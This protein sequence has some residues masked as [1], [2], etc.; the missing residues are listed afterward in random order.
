MPAPAPAAPP[1]AAPPAPPSAVKIVDTGPPKPPPAPTTVIR[2][3]ELPPPVEPLKPPAKGSA[4]ADMLKNLRSRAK[5]ESG[6]TAPAETPPAE[7]QTPPET[8]PVETPAGEKPTETP[9]ATEVKPGEKEKANPWKLVDQYKKRTAELEKEIAAVKTSTLPEQERATYTEKIT[10]LEASVKQYE[11][12]L[13]FMDYSQ[14]Q[15]FK[16]KYAD[17]FQNAWNVAMGELKEISITDPGTGQ[18]RPMGV[19]DMMQI[20]NLPLGQARDV[21]N[22]IAGDFADDIMAHRKEIRKL[23][24][25]QNQA[26]EK[27]KKDG[28]ER[29]KKEG[30]ATQK[31][32]AEITKTLA[33]TWQEE[34]TA[35]LN[36]EKYGK[37]LKPVEGD[38]EWNT[39]LKRGF[40]RADQTFADKSPK[41]PTLT[42]DERA[43]IVKRHV[44]MRNRSAAFGALRYR[45]E[46]QQAR[47]AELEAKL[48]EYDETVPPTAGG[49]HAE[50]GAPGA[51][52][53]AKQAVYGALRGLAK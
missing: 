11:D 41:D 15:E 9:P 22:K 14:S 40:E 19:D 52:T 35:L 3:S 28:A 32:T 18:Q 29:V 7:K 33:T 37:Y 10:K 47:I 30:E 2:A 51:P 31:Q 26:L 1:P 4:R 12:K 13:A 8:K 34:N 44:A 53:T 21:A 6:E 49:G 20:V 5:N 27:A 36:H 38:E 50:P 42:P 43:E 16:E 25:A 45:V 24:D 17:P 46:Q 23:Y 39:R 48:K